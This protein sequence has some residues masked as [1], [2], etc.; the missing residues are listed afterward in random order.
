MNANRK[1]LSA[2]FCAITTGSVFSA[3]ITVPGTSDPWLAGMTNGAT[4]SGG[5]FAPAQSPAEV[6]GM[7]VF[8]AE[9]LLFSASGTVANKAGLTRFGP[10]GN[11]NGVLPHREGAEN[12][13]SSCRAPIN[14]LLGVF[15]GPDLPSLTPAP[16]TLDFGAQT[17]RDYANLSPALKQVFFI[18]DGHTSSGL[19]QS[20]T[21]PSGATRLFLGSMDGFTWFDNVGAFIVTVAPVPRLSIRVIDSSRSSISWPTNAADYSLEYTTD[22]PAVAWIATTNSA[23]VEG[24]QIVVTVSEMFHQQFFRLRRH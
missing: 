4:A 1:M 23:V 12:G 6:V 22:L 13:I 11:T 7:Q 18:G 9:F 15:L 14:S 10:E 2:V 24:D 5:D 8:P 21:V 19:I 16:A 3:T 17:A 20:I